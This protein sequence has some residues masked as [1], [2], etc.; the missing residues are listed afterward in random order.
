MCDASNIKPEKGEREHPDPTVI[1]SDRLALP[2][3]A[4]RDG[5]WTI[6]GASVPGSSH[7]DIGVACQDAHCITRINSDVA[8][9]VVS[10]GAGSAEHSEVSS[11]LIVGRCSE[12]MY[13]MA[14]EWKWCASALPILEDEW[15]IEVLKT[16]GTIRAEILEL[17]DQKNLPLS[18]FHATV[19]CLIFSA[20]GILLAHI[21][22]G[23]A[24]YRD[25]MGSW[26]PAMYPSKGE[27]AGETH[28]ITQD[29][30]SFP[31][32]VKTYVINAKIDAI[33]ALSDGCENSVWQDYRE[34]EEGVFIGANLP[35][36]PFFDSNID[37]LK[38]LRQDHSLEAVSRLWKDYLDK[39]SFFSRENDDKTL[40]VGFVEASP[41]QKE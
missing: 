16:F 15:R 12:L 7:K 35:Y 13:P 33:V 36:A 9:V 6:V 25:T 14:R 34:L 20:N 40:I 39:D 4:E 17:A 31:E 24:G 19:I 26:H 29:I 30:L 8:M 28:F 23:R 37:A 21:G 41:Q 1:N 27:Q 38:R 5:V 2:D 11:R 10:D 32:I 22:D 3:I 18:S